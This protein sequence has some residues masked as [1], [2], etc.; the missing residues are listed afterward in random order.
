MR[1][2]LFPTS[3]LLAFVVAGCSG[4]GGTA[5]L[6]PQDAASSAGQPSSSAALAQ[7]AA[8]GHGSAP[9]AVRT[10]SHVLGRRS[11][12]PLTAASKSVHLCTPSTDPAHA[13]CFADVRTDSVISSVFPDDVNGLTPNDLSTL[14]KYP[15]P[16]HQGTAGKGQTVGI[17]VVGN[18]AALPSDLNVYRSHFGL[19]ACTTANGC[20]SKI[21]TPASSQVAALTGGQS[22]I[23][24]FAA[25]PSSA[26]WAGEA[27]ADTQVISATCPNCKILVSEAATDSISDLS[28]AVAAAINSGATVVNA[29]FGA[30]EAATDWSLNQMNTYYNYNNV[31]VVAAAGDSGY[32]VNFPASNPEVIAVGGTTLAVSGSTVSE[33]AW[34]GTGSGCSLLF[35]RPSWQKV[36]T[37]GCTNR[38][39][40]DISAV[41]DPATGVAVYD[42]TLPGTS[43]GWATFGG[44]SIATPIITGML[45]ISGKAQDSFYGGQPLYG[46]SSSNF[47]KVTSGSN[48]TCAIAV[49]CTALDGYNG[50]TGLGV[51]QGLGAF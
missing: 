46:A 10:L 37:A 24:A 26:G 23:V 14:Y 27:D 29:S 20:L 30:P 51:P 50:P 22:S 25:L 3:L 32:G 21:A 35:G 28:N 13:A 47:L 15:A 34:S 49:L 2:L 36:S 39:V 18:Y 6:P 38:A 8:R 9:S 33:S 12:V 17:V 16:A 7:I 4:S 1:H 19:P 5:A 42:S 40:V 43:G 44:T 31:K 41:A 11:I 48:G 45:A